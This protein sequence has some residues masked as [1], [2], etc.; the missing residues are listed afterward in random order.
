MT[1]PQALRERIARLEANQEHMTRQVAAMSVQLAEVHE[2]LL[3]AK[4]A[5]WAIIGVATAGGFIAAKAGAFL[6]FLR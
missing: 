3:K 4:G 5:R 2:L 6:P 1:G